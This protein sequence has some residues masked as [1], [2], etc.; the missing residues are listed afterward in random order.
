MSHFLFREARDCLNEQ[1]IAA[2]KKTVHQCCVPPTP[3]AGRPTGYNMANTEKKETIDKVQSI[4]CK[5][6]IRKKHTS[7]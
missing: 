5:E 4:T 2:I 3:R 7:K 1:I 6:N